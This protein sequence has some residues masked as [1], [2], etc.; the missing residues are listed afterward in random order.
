MI[1]GTEPFN[2]ERRSGYRVETTFFAQHQAE[3]LTPRHTVLESLQDIAA[4]QT[5]TE[6]RGLL[7]AFLFSGDD[8]FKPVSV[9]SGGERS[10]VA[11]ARTLLRPANFLVLDEPTNHLDIQSIGVLT[12]ALRQ[13]TGT[14]VIVSHD[15]HF[16]DQVINKVWRV[17][18]GTVRTYFGNYSDFLWQARHGT[19]REFVGA[20]A[21][22]EAE[23]GQRR[24]RPRSGGPKTRERKR[25]EAEE[26][27]RRYREARVSGTMTPG[28]MTPEQLRKEYQRLEETILEQ[29]QL[30]QSL[31]VDL[32]NSDV[33]SDAERLREATAAYEAVRRDLA[34]LYERWEQ[35]ADL[36]T[37]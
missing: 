27:N 12:E 21:A 14:F 10:R 22:T 30:Q 29:E 33:Y 1:V 34:E 7:G 4:G 28:S 23:D 9:L 17:G 19:A 36:L 18:G 20:V 32:S 15:R 26:R 2:G 16:L 11:L 5:E 37:D 31:E 24:S 35:L 3:S 6:I 8:V 13:Y 25:L